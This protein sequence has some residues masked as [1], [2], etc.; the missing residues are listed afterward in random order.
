M[1]KKE[2]IELNS[3][4]MPKIPYRKPPI[5]AYLLVGV[6]LL[7]AFAALAACGGL[8]V[9][10]NDSTAPESQATQPSATLDAGSIDTTASDAW[11]TA[12]LGQGLCGPGYVQRL[13]APN[14]VVWCEGPTDGVG[15]CGELPT[16]GW[17]RAGLFKCAKVQP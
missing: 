2:W 12:D 6:L 1:T 11:W 16:I 3:R 10:P 15:A 5:L 17:Y 9:P 8:D 4:P 13:Y 14:D 7:F